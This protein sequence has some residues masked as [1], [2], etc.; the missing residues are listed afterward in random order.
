MAVIIFT[1][2][3]VL[4]LLYCLRVHLVLSRKRSGKYR[5]DPEHLPNLSTVSVS[6]PQISEVPCDS[7]MCDSS[8]KLHPHTRELQ[9]ASGESNMS[10]GVS[11]PQEPSCDSVKM[12]CDS[13]EMP[14]D[15][16]EMCDSLTM[17]CP[18]DQAPKEPSCDSDTPCGSSTVLR[19][20][21]PEYQEIVL[22]KSPHFN[23]RSKYNNLLQ[24]VVNQGLDPPPPYSN[25]PG[26][27]NP[28][29]TS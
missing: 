2:V 19:P 5:T 3:I 6:K 14:C 27:P 17:L 8:T 15:S 16:A 18:Q 20:Q 13:E 28:K 11:C 23:V 9:E 29:M 10:R 4:L 22:M 7:D 21:E 24:T 1:L 26:I 12:S 25:T